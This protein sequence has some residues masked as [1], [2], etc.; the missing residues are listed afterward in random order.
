M[1]LF[2]IQSL[3]NAQFSSASVIFSI[4]TVL[5]IIAVVCSCLLPETTG[6]SLEEISDE[7]GSQKLYSQIANS[8]LEHSMATK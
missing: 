1:G 2:K 8:E 3:T 5:L 6:K 4:M 7:S